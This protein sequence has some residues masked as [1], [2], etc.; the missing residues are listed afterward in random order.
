MLLTTFDT[1]IFWP[2]SP[3]FRNKGY[4]PE[5]KFF[6]GKKFSK[7]IFSFQNTFWN[8]LNRFRPKK[9]S[10]KFRFFGHFLPFLGPKI[11]LLSFWGR[12]FDFFTHFNR[13]IL[14][15]FCAMLSI[16]T[17]IEVC[18]LTRF[19]DFLTKNCQKMEVFWKFRV[20]KNFRK[21]FL[22]KFCKLFCGYFKPSYLHVS[23]TIEA[24]SPNEQIGSTAAGDQILP[25]SPAMPGGNFLR[26]RKFFSEF[27][28]S[29]IFRQTI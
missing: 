1:R 15:S 14:R 28:H 12:I 27:L 17:S 9:I 7:S 29:N 13:I 24:C 23:L 3:I 26:W 4:V 25:C 21:F 2:L 19:I 20:E 10:K 18:K 5:K 11:D 6:N 8:I 22:P 16:P